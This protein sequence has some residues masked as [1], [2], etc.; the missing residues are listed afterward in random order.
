MNV[1]CRM[2]ASPRPAIVRDISYSGCKLEVPGAAVELGGTA[3]LEVPGTKSVS[4]RVVWAA[5]KMGG[6]Q[7]ERPLGTPAAIVFG[8]EEAPVEEAPVPVAEFQPQRG[9]G[10]S[11]WFRRL[12]NCFS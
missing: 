7:F 6:V 10:L 8:L 5:G 9:R 11:H 2:P 12:A 1:T 4:G 3:L